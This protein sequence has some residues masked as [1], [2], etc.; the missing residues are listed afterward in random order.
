MADNLTVKNAA[1]ADRT[2]RTTDLG[3]EVHVPHQNLARFGDT[4]VTIGQKAATASIPVVLASDQPT[5]PVNQAGVTATGALAAL[6]AVVA[7]SLNGATGFAVD[8][9]GTFVATV[10]I[11]GTINGTDW[12]ALAVIPAGSS[13]Q[14]A[15]VTTATAVGAWVGNANGLQQ[16]RAIATA[17]TS[18]SVTVVLRA[19]QAAGVVF[20]MPSGAVNQTVT[21]TNLSTNVAQVGGTATVSGGVAGTLGVGGTVAEDTAS[22]GNPVLVGGVARTALPAA[23]IIAG[24]AVRATF[25]TSGQLIAKNFAPAD[26]DFVVNQTVTTN[27]QTAIRAAQ[28][29]GVRQNIT[30]ITYQNTSAVATTLTIQ[31]GSTTLLFVSIPASMAN[32]VQLQFPTPLRGTANTALNYT[33]G[34]T[35]SSVALN[36]TGFNSY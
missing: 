27:T 24:D 1:G 34:T 19:M 7:L 25:S 14:V 32:P 36:T 6:N 3:A 35:G 5:L 15:T 30:A 8:L 33:A 17:Y 26:L 22:T 18:G 9:R 20:A 16:V 13:S 31:D 21:A 10:T 11:Q 23:T 29:A 4:A 2:L 28:G 12:F